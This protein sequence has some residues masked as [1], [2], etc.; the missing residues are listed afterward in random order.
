MAA[1]RPVGAAQTSRAAAAAGAWP[2]RQAAASTTNPTTTTTTTRYHTHTPH[3]LQATAKD[4]TSAAYALAYLD[5]KSDR[6]LWGKLFAK[7]AQLKGS[8]D[9]A[10]LSTFLWAASTA[11]V[12]CWGGWGWGWRRGWWRG[13]RAPAWL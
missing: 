9:A 3:R 8:F 13:G 10:S 1:R 11:K 12:C 7:A 6:R 2:R 4:L 5:A